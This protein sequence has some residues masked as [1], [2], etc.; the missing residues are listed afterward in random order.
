MRR[1]VLTTD[2]FIRVEITD[3]MRANARAESAKYAH[4][5]NNSIRSGMG[6]YAGC[7]GEEMVHAVFPF[8][9][10]VNT[11]ECDFEHKGKRYEIKTKDRTVPP[12]MDYECSVNDMNGRQDTDYYFFTS[13]LKQ[14]REFYV[15]WILGFIS[16][17]QLWESATL[18]KKG[19]IDPRNNFT[20]HC[21]TYNLYH[22]D[23]YAFDKQKL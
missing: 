11:Y 7:L 12:R 19:Q 15:G 9:N 14:D 4:L 17:E 22:R 2:D 13:L 10:R 5:L 6:T 20:F 16:K 3:E 23:L 18:Y 21:D 1:K 8:L